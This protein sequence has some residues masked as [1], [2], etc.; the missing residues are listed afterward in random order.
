MRISIFF[1]AVLLT[2]G[3][4]MGQG[5]SAVD[6]M[7]NNP[8]ND[9][10]KKITI[11]ELKEAIQ[12]SL[13]LEEKTGM[14]EI[15][16]TGIKKLSVPLDC[17]TISGSIYADLVAHEG[18]TSIK[19]QRMLFKFSAKGLPRIPMPPK[20]FYVEPGFFY[21]Y[22]AP[23]WE[24]L[25]SL[26]ET[27][28]KVYGGKNK[29]I[30]NRIKL[31][32]QFIIPLYM[33]HRID[34][35]QRVGIEMKSDQTILQ[36]DARLIESLMKL[37]KI[38]RQNKEPKPENIISVRGRPEDLG[39]LYFEEGG[40]TSPYAIG[41]V[42]TH[43]YTRFMLDLGAYMWQG[44]RAFDPTMPRSPRM[45]TDEAVWREDI[46]KI[47]KEVSEKDREISEKAMRPPPDPSGE[48]EDLGE[49]EE[50]EWL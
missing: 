34:F 4:A 15:R 30:K 25:P 23:V 11:N 10:Y 43:R 16:M 18:L 3:V 50:D 48:K 28:K 46:R 17:Y 49:E 13:E 20:P 19:D 6:L 2:T 7:E 36:F 44:D 39:T 26:W 31:T 27:V 40:E 37:E 38:A 5:L 47:Y 29:E 9:T 32:Y 35:P 8:I 22:R 45:A 24:L 41:Q 21:G 42:Q 12:L 33:S 14:V 1:L